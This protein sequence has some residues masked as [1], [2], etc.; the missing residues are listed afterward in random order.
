MDDLEQQC[1][2]AVFEV[3]DARER[4][5]LQCAKELERSIELTNEIRMTRVLV[6]PAKILDV[7]SVTNEHSAVFEK[8]FS[9]TAELLKTQEHKLQVMIDKIDNLTAVLDQIK[10]DRLCEVNKLLWH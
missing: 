4:Y 9:E 6:K 1:E 8:N 3:C 5:P 2:D 7:P 10:R